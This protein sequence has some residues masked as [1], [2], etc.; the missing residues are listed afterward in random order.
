MRNFTG[1]TDDLGTVKLLL[2]CKPIPKRVSFHLSHQIRNNADLLVNG[3]RS[4]YTPFNDD[5][6]EKI[7]DRPGPVNLVAQSEARKIGS[8]IQL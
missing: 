2:R 5:A 3:C 8:L 4:M 1:A 7:R 6:W